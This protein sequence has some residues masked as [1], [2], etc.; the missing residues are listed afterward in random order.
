MTAPADTSTDIENDDLVVKVQSLVHEYLLDPSKFEFDIG[1]LNLRIHIKGPAWAGIV[2]KTVAKFLLD[3]DKK[4]TDELI[5]HGIELPATPHGIIA[6]KVE[7]GSLDAFLQYA[8]GIFQEVRKMKPKDQLFIAGVVLG[9]AG[10]WQ[11]PDIIE[12]WNAPAEAKIES[13]ERV[14]LVKAVASI[15]DN[16]RELEAPLR[17]LV[18][19]MSEEDKISLPGHRSEMEKKDAKEVLVKGTRS[20]LQT[21]YIDGRYIVEELATKTKDWEIGLR[22]GDVVF[23]AKLMITSEEIDE[24]M[25]SYQAAHASGDNIAP[26]FQVTAEINAKGVQSATVI[27]VGEARGNSK[28]LGEIFES[29]KPDYVAK[30]DEASQEAGEPKEEEADEG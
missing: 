11:L 28:T 7:D 8:K 22:W 13:D 15:A 3:L 19:K 21:F 2:D 30:P 24:L 18:S 10:F 27:G 9:V 14:A 25:N 29:F 23:R 16:S 17:A 4:L 6:L 5:K 12:K 26:D 20:K 1:A